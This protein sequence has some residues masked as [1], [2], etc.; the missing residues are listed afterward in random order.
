[1]PHQVGAQH[2]AIEQY[3]GGR[4]QSA[5]A[6][7]H[8][9]V[10]GLRCLL[11]QETRQMTRDRGIGRIGQPDLRET[12]LA[13][14]RHVVAGHRGQKA[15]FQET[16]D[17]FGRKLG[18]DRSAHQ[19][20][21]A[22]ENRH[23]LLALLVVLREQPFLGQPALLPKRMQLHGLE[24]GPFSGKLLLDMP[25]QRQID[26]VAAQQNMFADSHALQRQF[27]SLLGDRDQREIRGAAAD[28]HH[29][30]QIAH[31]DALAPIGMPLDPGVER[32]LRLF[33]QQQILIAGL[34]GGFQRQLS[35]HRVERRGHRHQHLLLDERRV[36]HLRIPS[37]AQM[38][39]IAARCFHRGNSCDAFGRVERK[40]GRRAIDAR[41]G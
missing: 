12:H 11:P 17:I 13:A 26:I 39:Q 2:P 6:A 30:N 29:Q 8:R 34:F 25:G 10:F 19:S 15:L 41:M 3:V 23:G 14:L 24:L 37:L 33:E 35:R 36:R 5:R 22:S 21:A 38:F 4:R 16:L 20:C 7:T 32:R 28:V 1:M 18:L 9:S 27:S 40:D 31:R